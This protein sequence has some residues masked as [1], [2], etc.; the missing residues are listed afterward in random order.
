MLPD[1]VFV[2]YRDI[3]SRDFDIPCWFVTVS[4]VHDIMYSC[5]FIF[6]FAFVDWT[7]CRF[8]V[9]VRVARFLMKS[10]RTAHCDFAETFSMHVF[11]VFSPTLCT[12]VFPHRPVRPPVRP[13]PRIWQFFNHNFFLPVS[14]SVHTH[15]ANPDIF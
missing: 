11:Y 8:S 6:L 14:A 12:P 15:P 10:S 3:L 9:P 1:S 13:R 7:V 2:M 4:S 5:F